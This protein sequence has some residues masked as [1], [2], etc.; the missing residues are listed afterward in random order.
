M[1][2]AMLMCM[3][4]STSAPLIRGWVSKGLPQDVVSLTRL[5]RSSLGISCSSKGLVAGRLLIR[6]TQP[7]A[8]VDGLQ[9]KHGI[10]MERAGFKSYTVTLPLVTNIHLNGAV[11][12]RLAMAC[13]ATD[14]QHLSLQ[15]MPWGPLRRSSTV[16]QV[17]VQ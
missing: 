3:H 8:G 1:A 9:N 17:L 10:T 7:G 13:C 6:V 2:T 4:H 14:S 12:R 11:G 5:P 15:M 16:L